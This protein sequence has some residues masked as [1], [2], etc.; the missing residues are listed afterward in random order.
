VSRRSPSAL[1]IG[2]SARL[3]GRLSR[4]MMVA[5]AAS[6]G[7]GSVDNELASSWDT[8]NRLAHR[9][10]LSRLPAMTWGGRFKTTPH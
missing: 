6:S 3:D 5:N 10:H 8:T 2:S 7:P 1:G 4:S 9:G